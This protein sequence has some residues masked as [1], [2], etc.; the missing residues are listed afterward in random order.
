MALNE[1]RTVTLSSRQKSSPFW[2][3]LLLVSRAMDHG[4]IIAWDFTGDL[5]IRNSG[6]DEDVAPA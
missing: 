2:I 3:T 6:W 5:K 1:A 4:M